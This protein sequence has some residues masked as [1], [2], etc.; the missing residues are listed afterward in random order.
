M[1]Q[2][3]LCDQCDEKLRCREVFQRLGAAQGPSVVRNVLAAFVLPLVVFIGSLAAAE[4]LLAGRVRSVELR[5]AL[6]FLLAF[7]TTFVLILA[8]R[9]IMKRLGK[10]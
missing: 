3:K 7:L 6:A 10:T 4:Y 2:H 5:T 9:F 8:V 1:A